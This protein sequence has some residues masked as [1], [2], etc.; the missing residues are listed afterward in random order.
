MR[1][2]AIEARLAAIASE[3]ESRGAELTADQLSA[4][5]TEVNDLKTERAGIL[6]ANEQRSNLLSSIAEGRE[7]G[8]T[9][10]RSFPS[11]STPA[12][13]DE[14]RALDDDRYATVEYRRAF[15]AYAL[16]GTPIPAEYRADA[17]TKTTDVGAVI[18][19]TV[20]NKI[21]EKLEAVGMIL[22]LVTR[23]AYRG[24]LA[25]PVSTAKPVATW[26]NEG[27]GSDK[28]K[29]TVAKDGMITFAYHKLRCAVAV[30]LEVDTMAM[31]AFE[32]TLINNAVEAMTKAI[33][34][35]IV[36][37]DGTGK[38][39]GILA[40]T[41]AT[42]QALT[43]GA[44]SYADLI[45]AEAA[46]P[47]A[48]ENGAVW[49]MSKKTF[50]SYY[51][52]QDETGQPIGRVNYG[53]A[54]KPERSLLGRPVVVCDY[55][56]SYASGLATGQVFAFLFNFADYVLNTNYQMGIKKYEDNDTDDL[57]TKAIMLVD[58]KVVDNNSLVTIAKSA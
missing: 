4:L 39:K 20:L 56:P 43:S 30:S 29:K 55:V 31:S 50:M 22:P 17:L 53:L 49:C 1:L 41:P 28:Q 33:E 54:G 7:A 19:T 15:M 21:V 44:P 34:Q 57:V 58:G 18:P 27:A 14:A 5:E 37:G 16:R 10:T 23:T 47:Q 36:S 26:V 3:I 11:P 45:N 8:A 9:V 24:G 46:L 12:E 52:L 42:G 40:E 38:P 6:A 51:G 35:A 48:Y 25:I 32:A 13:G 2:A